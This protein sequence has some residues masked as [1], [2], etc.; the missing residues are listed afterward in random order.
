MKNMGTGDVYVAQME[1][2]PVMNLPQALQ[3]ICDKKYIDE[4]GLGN[5]VWEAV[6]SMESVSKS[7]M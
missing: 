7:S 3:R 4:E 6:I 2:Y 5:T 1:M